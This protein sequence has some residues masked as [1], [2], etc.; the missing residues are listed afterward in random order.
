MYTFQHRFIRLFV[1]LFQPFSIKCYISVVSPLKNNL[2]Y[3]NYISKL[4]V[5]NVPAGIILQFTVKS[6]IPRIFCVTPHFMVFQLQTTFFKA[7]GGHQMV[8]DVNV[9]TN[10]AKQDGAGDG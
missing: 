10:G 3:F 6:G 5:S 2:H 8:S 9:A 4:K 7:Y 1:Y